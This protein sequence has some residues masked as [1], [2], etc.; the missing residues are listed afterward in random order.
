MRSGAPDVSPRVAGA[1]D[2]E[3]PDARPRR[4]LLQQA[5]V[6]FVLVMM[7]S[8]GAGLL[9]AAAVMAGIN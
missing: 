2:A 7:A 4:G 3:Q 1:A 5:V 8:L 6:A 9:L